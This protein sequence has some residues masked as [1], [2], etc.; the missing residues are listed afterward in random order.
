MKHHLIAA[1]L[2]YA[3]ISPALSA[4]NMHH[5]TA[6]YR[7]YLAGVLLS[8]VDLQ[9][10]LSDNAYR[11]SAHIGP[12]GIGH[13][14]SDSH[15]VTTTKGRIETGQFVPQRLDL[16]WSNDDGVKST[17]MNYQRGVPV[18]F[19]SG[20]KLPPEAQPKNKVDINEV[21]SGSVDPFLAMLA[22]L[23]DNQ[24]N[25]ACN[26]KIRVFDGR[27]LATLSA[28]APK[29]VAATAHDYVVAIPLV[30]CAVVWQPIAGYSERSM[31]RADDLPPIEAHYGRIAD[32]AFAAPLD[33]RA[34][35]R[36]GNISL[37]AKRYFEPIDTL[38]APFDINDYLYDEMENE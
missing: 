34:E 36:Y 3:V 24:L 14:L 16:A 22:P 5:Y 21:G 27:R 30:S 35:T 23:R 28:A 33:M 29:A 10:S 38:P 37:Y 4:N 6:E 25:N 18:E 8:V 11:L 1:F 2:G 13:I 9:L 7:L 20:Y 12:A 19:F 15:V 32:T 26:G 31:A 17:Y